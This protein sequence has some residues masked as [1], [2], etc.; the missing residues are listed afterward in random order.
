MIYGGDTRDQRVPH[1]PQHMYHFTC[2][3]LQAAMCTP[4]EDATPAAVAL[5]LSATTAAAALEETARVQPGEV[6]LVTAAAGGTGGSAST[7]T[8]IGV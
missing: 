3:K 8:M 7:S 2:H 1:S 6:V 5:V 4:V